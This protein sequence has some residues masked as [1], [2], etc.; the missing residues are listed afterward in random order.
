[1]I[2]SNEG[3]FCSI[4]VVC[5]VLKSNTEAASVG[6]VDAVSANTRSSS[7][8]A[9]AERGSKLEWADAGPATPDSEDRAAG[10]ALFW[11]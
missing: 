6:T 3:C 8:P 2:V 7:P 10:S 5:I 9:T 4:D 1:M 11:V